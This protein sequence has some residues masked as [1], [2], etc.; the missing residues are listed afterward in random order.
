MT[1]FHFLLNFFNG[2]SF[3]L[4]FLER[5]YL[6]GASVDEPNIF[7]LSSRLQDEVYSVFKI[8]GF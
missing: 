1:W 8:Q 6:L 5:D 4:S 2:E 7:H 3:M